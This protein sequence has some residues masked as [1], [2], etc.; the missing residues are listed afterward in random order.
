MKTSLFLIVASLLQSTS[1]NLLAGNLVQLSCSGVD[2]SPC[3]ENPSNPKCRAIMQMIEAKMN[4]QYEEGYGQVP[5]SRRLQEDSGQDNEHKSLRGG[6][7]ELQ[8][9][10]CSSCTYASS[11]ICQLF[12]CPGYCGDGMNRALVEEEPK[13]CTEEITL[14][15][16]LVDFPTKPI[17]KCFEGVKCVMEYQC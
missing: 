3:F 4:M 5:E 14:D 12:C 6:N 9:N 16:Y 13:V 11:L 17:E 10:I 7:R 8:F 2:K 1:A 15:T